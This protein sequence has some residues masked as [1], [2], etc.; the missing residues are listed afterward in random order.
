MKSWTVTE[1]LLYV[2]DANKLTDSERNRLTGLRFD[3]ARA[4][5]VKEA[6]LKDHPD[7]HGQVYRT[8]RPANK[9]STEGAPRDAS[10]RKL[11]TRRIFDEKTGLP[12]HP[13]RSLYYDPVMNPYGVAPPGMPYA[14]RREFHVCQPV[15][16]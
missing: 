12:R 16:C 3:L 7:E 2:E 14:E 9:Q 1:K 13:E 4:K 15:A 5:K 6:Y 10:G 11:K 8:R